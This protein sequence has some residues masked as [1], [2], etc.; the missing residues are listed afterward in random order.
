MVSCFILFIFFVEIFFKQKKSCFFQ[1]LSIV[2]TKE[3]INFCSDWKS[4]SVKVILIS[5]Q[6]QMIQVHFYK[7]KVLLSQTLNLTWMRTIENDFCIFWMI[8][9]DS[10]KT[11]L[12]IPKDLR[13]LLL[14][15][16]LCGIFLQKKNNNLIKLIK[17]II[18]SDHIWQ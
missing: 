5:Y 14:L 16:F 11:I 7:K 2:W 12:Q 6:I 9:I 18:S 15:I 17:N 4:H 13:I 8:T 10:S 1:W 3:K